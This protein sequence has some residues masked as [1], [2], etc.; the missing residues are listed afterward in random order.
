MLDSKLLSPH[1]KLRA[2][3]TGIFELKPNQTMA[4]KWGEQG[5]HVAALQQGLN[6]LREYRVRRAWPILEEDGHFG[7]NTFAA[8]KACQNY[9]NKADRQ[10]A[11]NDARSYGVPGKRFYQVLYYG[12]RRKLKSDGLPGLKTLLEMD[13]QLV[14]RDH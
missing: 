2:I 14:R 12:R 5:P 13:V 4:V 8:V 6:I 11:E 7:N 9:L 1:H 10:F 3:A